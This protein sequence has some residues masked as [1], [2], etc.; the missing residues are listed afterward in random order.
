MRPDPKL[1]PP[2][3][4]LGSLY[5]LGS[6]A[7][8]LEGSPDKLPKKLLKALRKRLGGDRSTEAFSLAELKVVAL[9]LVAFYSRSRRKLPAHVTM[10]LGLLMGMSEDDVRNPQSFL[11][12][13]QTVGRPSRQAAARDVAFYLD[14]HHWRVH[15]ELM[16]LRSLWTQVANVLGVERTKSV[17]RATLEAWREEY[18]SILGMA[19]LPNYD[20]PILPE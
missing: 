15:Q 5:Y 14:M 7:N 6:I 11:E 19:P 9:D 16:P 10:M 17:S 2:I 12:A 1:P 3:W 8:A 20:E 4:R 18:V 13:G